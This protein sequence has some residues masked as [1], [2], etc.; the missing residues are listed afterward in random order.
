MRIRLI[1]EGKTRNPQLRAL[2]HDYAARLK[3]F[4][5]IAIEEM[6]IGP[7][8]SKHTTRDN[9]TMSAAERRLLD[10]LGPDYKIMLDA[11]GQQWT[12]DEFAR[13]LEERA[14]RGTRALA[15]LV[16]A[17]AGFS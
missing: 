10:R 3:H 6:P 13:W 1:W 8:G 7:T 14:V 12:S 5:E 11:G 16:G 9:G 4:V 17:P 15:F 2:E